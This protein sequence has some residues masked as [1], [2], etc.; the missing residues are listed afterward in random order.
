MGSGGF[1]PVLGFPG[2]WPR[3]VPPLAAGEF[4]VLK[5]R[6]RAHQVLRPQEIQE[7]V[8]FVWALRIRRVPVPGQKINILQSD[9]RR[10]LLRRRQAKRAELGRTGPDAGCRA[11]SMK[12]C[13]H[14]AGPSPSRLNSFPD[15]AVESR[16]DRNE[17]LR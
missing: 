5:P 8:L 2:S 13:L 1:L 12:G 3:L 10:G 11:Q 9:V 7:L 16:S 4:R 14:A 15:C 6:R 17:L